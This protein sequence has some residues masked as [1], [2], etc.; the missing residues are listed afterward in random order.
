MSEP[1]PLKLAQGAVIGQPVPAVVAYLERLLD[2]AK[3]GDLRALA[4]ACVY[5]RDGKPDGASNA[6]FVLGPFTAYGMAYAIRTL[7]VKFDDHVRE[8]IGAG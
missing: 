4:V 7:G 8:G 2:Q 3:T 6:G 1:V 5:A